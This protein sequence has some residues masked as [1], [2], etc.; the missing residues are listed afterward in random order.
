MRIEPNHLEDA[1]KVRSIV[2]AAPFNSKLY[3]KCKE[4]E[5]KRGELSSNYSKKY[6]MKVSPKKIDRRKSQTG[7]S[8]YCYS[9]KLF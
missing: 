3:N 5:K 1:T 9:I 2:F 4:D 8:L 6:A 7:Y